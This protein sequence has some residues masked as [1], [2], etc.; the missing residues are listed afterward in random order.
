MASTRNQRLFALRSFLKYASISNPELMFLFME[1]SGI[2]PA[3]ET[4]DPVAFLSEIAME[5]LLRQP[6]DTTRTGL[7]DMCFM[8]TMYDTAARDCEMLNLRLD[9]LDLNE[10]CPKVRLEGKGNKIRQVPLMKKTVHHLK[11]YI[12]VFHSSESRGDDW[13]FYT[14]AHGKKNKMSDDNVARF[15]KKYSE[16]AKM[17]CAEVPDKVTPHQFRHTRAMHLYRHGMSLQLLSEYMG[18][19]SIVSTQIYAY[20]DTEMKR[21]AIEKIHGKPENTELPEWQNDEELIRKLYGL[22]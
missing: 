1:A 11:R 2:S 8:V 18:H 22:E 20:A 7:R 4:K 5:T 16:M 17:E 15:L 14:I 3:R 9:S 10:S 19:A 6:D 13:L 21:R 12:R